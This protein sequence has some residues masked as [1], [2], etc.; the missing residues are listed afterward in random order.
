M[1]I[2]RIVLSVSLAGSLGFGVADVLTHSN[3][4]EMIRLG[5]RITP[6]DSAAWMR[7]AR[8]TSGDRSTGAIEEANRINP[9]DSGAWIALGLLAEAEGDLALARQRFDHAI[10]A[11]KGFL[12]VWTLANFLFRHND[13]QYLPFLRE[14]LSIAMAGSQDTT[15]VFDLAWQAGQDIAGSE[16]AALRSYVPYLIAA[17]HAQA[18][19]EAAMRS[20]DPNIRL[21]TAQCLMNAGRMAEFRKLTGV[22]G[23]NSELNPPGEWSFDWKY[24]SAPEHS[25]DSTIQG[26]DRGVRIDLSGS[27]PETDRPDQRGGRD[28]IPGSD[29]GIAWD[30][31]VETAHARPKLLWLVSGA[32]VDASVSGQVHHHRQR[33][34]AVDAPARAGFRRTGL[35]RD[36]LDQETTHRCSRR[37]VKT[38]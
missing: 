22:I 36:Y 32:R 35:C 5:L 31:K 17:G 27:Q 24:N 1:L 25:I 2:Q 19:F 21:Q 4:P 26:P 8:A 18:A 16:P 20:D 37:V 13:P 9:R 38:G 23:F 6:T 3:S 29:T 33:G 28:S 34:I 11:D 30:T 15:A 12:P 7:L 10:V 14:A